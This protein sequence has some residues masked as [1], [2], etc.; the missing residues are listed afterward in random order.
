VAPGLAVTLAL[1]VLIGVLLFAVARPR[2]WPEAYA[3]VPGA[4]LL[5]VTGVISWE[6]AGAGLESMLPTLVF[7]AGMLVLAHLCQAEGLFD[8]AGSMVASKSG[9]RPVRLLVWVAGVAAVTTAVL[10]LDS[11]VVLLTPVVYVTASRLGVRPKPYAYATSH[12]ANSASLLLPVSNLT[13]LLALSV[14]GLSFT[15]FAALMAVPWLVAIVIEYVVLRLFFARE[16]SIH[17][18]AAQP[19]AVHRL[20]VVAAVVLACTLA[21]FAVCE[22]LGIAP[23][24]V[25]LAGAA[26]LAVKRL[27]STHE[28]RGKAAT[29]LVRA[30]NPLFLLF[31]A[32]LSVIVAAVV[33]KGAGTVISLVIPRS[34][35]LGALL[36]LA[37]VSAVLANLVNNLPA[38]L[39]LL[40]LAAPLGPVAVL[41]CL[42]GVNIGPNLTY[43]GSLA[44]LLWRRIVARHDEPVGLGEFSLLGVLTVPLS[45]A[46]CTIALWAVNLVIGV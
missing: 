4:L 35:N 13:N 6:D 2:G 7:L 39:V 16:L 46:A 25:A 11:T 37:L 41:A 26:V 22:P 9:G 19:M 31:V 44:T 29:D 18:P 14:V 1:V 28:H 33:D 5:C 12:L 40:P 17:A 20:P 30:V 10:S 42:I 24:W 38:I 15:H 32:G 36:I 34:V 27:V 8:W 3:G 23:F 45:L 21:G 43:F